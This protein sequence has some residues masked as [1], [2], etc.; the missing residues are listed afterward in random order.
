MADNRLM[1]WTIDRAKTHYPDDVCIMIEK[2]QNYLPED[3]EIRFVNKFVC[4]D[5]ALIPLA[6]TF[7]IGELSYDLMQYSWA[8]M[9]RHAQVDYYCCLIADSKLVYYR[10]EA[11]KER[12]LALQRRFHENLGDKAFMYKRALEWLN[13]AMELYTHMLF[14]EELGKLRKAAGYVA[15][16]LSWAVA[17]CNQT[18]FELGVLEQMTKLGKMADVPDGFVDNYWRIIRAQTA[19]E[20]KALVHQMVAMTR[21][22]VGDRKPPQP[23]REGGE[24]WLK[25]WY[26]EGRYYFRRIDHYCAAGDV[27]VTF[28][29]SCAMQAEFDDI[30]RDYDVPGLDVMSH[31][32]AEDLAAHGQRMRN[33]E[34]QIVQRIEADG[35]VIECYADLDEFLRKNR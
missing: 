33:A 22:F 15:D 8:H 32:D 20:L 5:E 27:A 17:A 26:E 6:R 4:E 24:Y 12:F 2:N 28:S 1:D 31:F 30:A 21:A 18:Y 23:K 7:I 19:E 11:D 25:P 16:Y 34:A 14:E 35:Q 29:L 10:S 9:E 3:R 13:E